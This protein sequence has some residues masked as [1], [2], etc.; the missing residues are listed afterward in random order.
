MQR[1]S[2]PDGPA[3][4]AGRHRPAHGRLNSEQLEAIQQ[5]AVQQPHAGHVQHLQP[6]SHGVVQQPAPQTRRQLDGQDA[7]EGTEGIQKRERAD[8]RTDG[9][10]DHEGA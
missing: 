2:D 1:N 8:D 10:A 5:Q 7:D 4:P 9:A 6:Q 3:L